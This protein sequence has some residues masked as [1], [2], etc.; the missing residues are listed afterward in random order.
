MA[1]KGSKFSP[2]PPLT[3]LMAARRI[4][5]AHHLEEVGLV[6]LPG[7]PSPCWEGGRGPVCSR[8]PPQPPIGWRG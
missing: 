1:T 4:P 3:F 5:L 2:S 7:T 6:W 8:S